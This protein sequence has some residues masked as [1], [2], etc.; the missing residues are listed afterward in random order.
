[1]QIKVAYSIPNSHNQKRTSQQ[2]NTVKIPEVH[3]KH[4]ILIPVREKQ[5]ITYKCKPN[6]IT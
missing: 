1:M 5:H 6:L 2:Y 4:G 3:H